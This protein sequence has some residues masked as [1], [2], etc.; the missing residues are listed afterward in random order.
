MSWISDELSSLDLGDSRRASRVIRM[1]KQMSDRPSGSVPETFDIGSDAKAAYR[2]LSSDAIDPQSLRDAVHD[3]CVSRLGEERVVL[4][5]QDTTSFDFTSHPS[6][7]GL[8]PLAHQKCSG[9]WMHSTLCVTTQGVPLGLIDQAVWARDRATAG[10]RHRRKELPIEAK[11]SYRWI[12]SLRAVHERTPA[13]TTV[14]TVADREADIFEVFVEPRPDNSE[15]LIRACRDR[16]VA[17]KRK[18]WE[19]MNAQKPCG[20]VTYRM[21]SGSQ[22]GAGTRDRPARGQESRG[23]VAA[24]D[25]SGV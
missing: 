2:A 4:A 8:G 12:E 23:V 7:E 22:R 25:A 14:I 19:Q 13:S 9:L 17:E 6:T 24:D 21:E 3:A 15:L 16:C 11:E 10:K 5:V 18:L 20:V 1:V